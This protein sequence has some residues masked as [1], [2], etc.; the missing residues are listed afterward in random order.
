MSTI[1]IRLPDDLEEQLVKEAKLEQKSRSVVAREAIREF[2]AKRE[3]ERFLSELIAEARAG[4][5]DP[6]IKREAYEIADDFLH[7]EIEALDAAEG[8]KRGRAKLDGRSEKWWK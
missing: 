8:S 7:L 3:R 1:S 4:Y 2:I 6:E 5:A